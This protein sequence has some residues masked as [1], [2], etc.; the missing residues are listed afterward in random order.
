MTIFTLILLPLILIGIIIFVVEAVMAR[1]Q[2][3]SIRPLPKLAL[4]SSLSILALCFCFQAMLTIMS[5]INSIPH[6]CTEIDV[7]LMIA[8]VILCGIAIITGIILFIRESIK[9]KRENRPRRSIYT[10]FFTAMITWLMTPV[11]CYLFVNLYTMIFGGD[12]C[13]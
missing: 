5:V 2:A 10:F 3:R 8:F 1:K 7:I 12:P 11:V 6:D 4:T 9:A 13:P